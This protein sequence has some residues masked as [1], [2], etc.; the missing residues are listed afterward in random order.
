MQKIIY[1][2]QELITQ[3]MDTSH[4][5]IVVAVVAALAFRIYKKYYGNTSGKPGNSGHK[6]TSFPSSSADDGY[7][8]YSKK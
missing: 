3:K 2:K 7:E 1:L 6:S 5:A 4:I 8:P